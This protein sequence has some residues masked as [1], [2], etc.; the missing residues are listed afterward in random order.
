MLFSD[1]VVSRALRLLTRALPP[2]R[3]E[4]TLAAIRNIPS[5]L[6]ITSTHRYD[7]SQ[8]VESHREMIRI[9]FREP[10]A[11]F[12][13]LA[14]TLAHKAGLA[15]ALSRFAS[16]VAAAIKIASE[17]EE[18]VAGDASTAKSP[19]YDARFGVYGLPILHAAGDAAVR[20][21]LTRGLEKED[22][23]ELL[24]A[25]ERAGGFE[26]ARADCLAHIDRAK[27][28]LERTAVP[29]PELLFNFAEFAETQATEVLSRLEL[30]L[31]RPEPTTSNVA[32]SATLRV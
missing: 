15:E 23:P 6:L 14:T 25:V 19:A 20:Q 3:L 13:E 1:Y 32:A 7:L 21:I 16:E 30:E 22:V 12:A 9:V 10:A 31:E 26:R 29:H 18:L 8:S 2:A 11:A 17:I 5:G 24:S 27:G 28:I 4:G